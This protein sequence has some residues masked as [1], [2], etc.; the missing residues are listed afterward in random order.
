MLIDHFESLFLQAK[1][2]YDELK[3]DQENP[4]R[5]LILYSLLFSSIIGFPALKM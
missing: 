4:G 1:G 3:L 5:I 2:S